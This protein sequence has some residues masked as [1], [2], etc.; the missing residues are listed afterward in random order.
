MFAAPDK[1]EWQTG[2]DLI[3]RYDLPGSEKFSNCFCSVCGSQV[4]YVTSDGAFL[5]VPAGYVSGDPGVRP[6]ANIFWGER[7]CWFD[8]GKSANTFEGYPE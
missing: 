8:E 1:I 6:T 2:T 4:P 3:N 7:P 5:V